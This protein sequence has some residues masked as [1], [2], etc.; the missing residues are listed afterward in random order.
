[1]K[2]N[3]VDL[4][5]NITFPC[6]EIEKGINLVA[7]NL[8]D[9]FPDKREF[10]NLISLL[11][12]TRSQIYYRHDLKQGLIYK[13]MGEYYLARKEKEYAKYCLEIAVELLK[14]YKFLN[15]EVKIQLRPLI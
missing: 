10:N 15:R 4:N 6:D 5:D 8:G 14:N 11:E 2:I 1:M 12:R 13:L 9:E 3:A 7:E